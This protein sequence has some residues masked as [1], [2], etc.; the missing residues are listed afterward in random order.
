[1]GRV[2]CRESVSY[3]SK[4]NF[5]YQIWC[6]RICDWFWEPR[7]GSHTFGSYINCPSYNGS[8]KSRCNMC[9]Q[10]CPWRNG[11]WVDLHLHMISDSY[12]SFVLS[13]ISSVWFYSRASLVLAHIEWCKS[14]VFKDYFDTLHCT[15]N[16]VMLRILVLNNQISCCLSD[17]EAYWIV[18][19]W[20]QMIFNA[21]VNQ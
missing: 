17:F 14:S 13:S 5:W 12:S 20:K 6:G 21:R 3:H 9:W 19:Y 16:C 4:L 15:Q 11:I 10:D 2:F 7:L 18:K 8:I 1:M